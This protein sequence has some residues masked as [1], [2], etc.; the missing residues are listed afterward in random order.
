MCNSANI[1]TLSAK[2]QPETVY[3]LK[4]FVSNIRTHEGHKVRRTVVC[5]KSDKG[6]VIRQVLISSATASLASIHDMIPMNITPRNTELLGA[7]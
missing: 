4:S 7:H 2:P 3:D 5:Y 1:Q 6:D